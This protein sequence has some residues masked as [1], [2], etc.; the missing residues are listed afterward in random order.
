[1]TRPNAFGNVI[2]LIV[3][4]VVAL[5]ITQHVVQ[6]LF[7]I[8]IFDFSSPRGRLIG[9]GLTM[10]FLFFV[11]TSIDDGEVQKIGA[12]AAYEQGSQQRIEAE[13]TST[14]RLVANAIMPAAT[15]TVG[16]GVARAPA[17]RPPAAAPQRNIDGLIP[18]LSI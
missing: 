14:D 7:G 2:N 10:M 12:M 1:M 13:T 4:E 18:S 6:A 17:A 11:Y 15:G 9:I 3:F 8:N 16:P 5:V